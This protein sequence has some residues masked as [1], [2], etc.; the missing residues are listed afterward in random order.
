MKESSVVGLDIGGANLKAANAPGTACSEV[1]EIWRAPGDLHLRLRTILDR[2]AQVDQ[3]AVTMTAELAD[4]FATKAEGVDFILGQVEQ[5]AG[6]IPIATW[7]TSGQFVSPAEARRRPLE[8]AAANWHALATW[9]GRLVPR[10]NAMLIDIGSTTSDLISLR[11]GLP[12]PVGRTDVTRLVS[13]E[14]VYTGARRTPVCCVASQ[15]PF[16]GSTVPLAAEWFATM[17]DVHLLLGNLPED[18]ADC[19]T[20]NGR[21]ASLPC[22]RDRLARAIC[23]DRDEVTDSE[24]E[25]ISRSLADQQRS[26][27]RQALGR[28]LDRMDGPLEAAIVSG[29]GEFLARQVLQSDPRTSA[30]PVTSLTSALSPAATD[31]ACAYAVAALAFEQAAKATRRSP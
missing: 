4:C 17:A 8:V 3:L 6:E 19:H 16:R 24:L 18:P 27:L 12:C 11:D 2:F 28:T 5:A 22:A 31:A 23:C 14:L 1:F 21:P 25:E 29:A 9:A 13:G 30:I 20:A 15:V 10:G 26:Q 7:V